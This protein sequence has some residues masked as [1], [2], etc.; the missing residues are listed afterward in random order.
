VELSRASANVRASVIC[1]ICPDRGS[2]GR[3]PV[4]LPDQTPTWVKIVHDQC[5]ARTNADRFLS[6]GLIKAQQSRHALF[7]QDNPR[8]RRRL[9]SGGLGARIP[10]AQAIQRPPACCPGWAR[11]CP[12]DLA[13]VCGPGCSGWPG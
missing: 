1:W 11:V 7:R 12:V 5:S 3:S 13:V 4:V 10:L 8:H 6:T 2:S 9:Y